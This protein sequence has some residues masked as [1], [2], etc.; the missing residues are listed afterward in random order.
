LKTNKILGL[1]TVMCLSITSCGNKPLKTDTSEDIAELSVSSVS[2]NYTINKL[3]T[4]FDSISGINNGEIYGID[5]STY[6]SVYYADTELPDESK[7]FTSDLAGIFYLK[8]QNN[9][10]YIYGYNQE[11][12]YKIYTYSSD[13]T[14][15][16]EIPFEDGH[17]TSVAPFQDGRI[18][19][20]V[21]DGL[22]NY[23]RIYSPDGEI[24]NTVYPDLMNEGDDPW[25]YD[26]VVINDDKIIL[27]VNRSENYEIL[28]FD[29][30]LEYIGNIYSDI[31]YSDN[32]KFSECNN[33]VYLCNTNYEQSTADFYSVSSDM[34]PLEYITSLPSVD[35]TVRCS[36]DYDFGYIKNDDLYG[37]K[38]S[39]DS[40]DKILDN[41]SPDYI[42]SCS[43]ALNYV[44]S[45]NKHTQQLV[46]KG[47]A[48]NELIY[49]LVDSDLFNYERLSYSE[50]FQALKYADRQYSVYD[51][52][53][54]NR[55][56]EIIPL[57]LDDSY[58]VNDLLVS[59][60]NIYVY[61]TD[62]SDCC[63]I[64]I[65]DRSGSEVYEYSSENIITDF[66]VMNDGGLFIIEEDS[67]SNEYLYSVFNA[68][69]YEPVRLELSEIPE[70]QC[71]NAC[72]PSYKDNSVYLMSDDYVYSAITTVKLQHLSH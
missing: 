4:D 42:F 41:T 47:S 59:K 29:S 35:Y 10:K 9:K 34:S 25:V 23:L 69:K 26:S 19:V 52:S 62:E 7:S 2:H 61:L 57:N 32:L 64:K 15:C 14:E 5:Y 1:I 71:L 3:D 18:F 38:V 53:L 48:K 44:F 70:E 72:F 12:T 20:S 49:E 55:D 31:E 30:N 39:E 68:G 17:C 16:S 65:F 51:I 11:D 58:Y 56:A 66:S 50:H 67:I 27:A 45:D 46:K 54:K 36:G 8:E 24:L 63:Y 21:L 60:S 6:Y 22:S 37:F 43:G 33:A 40:S 28:A 13:M